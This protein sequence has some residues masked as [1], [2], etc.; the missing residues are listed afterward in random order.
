MTR[1]VALFRGINVGKAKRIAMAELRALL[2][3]LGYGSCRLC[4]TAAM[5]Y[6]VGRRA[7]VKPCVAADRKL[8][9]MLTSLHKL[10]GEERDLNLSEAHFIIGQYWTVRGNTLDTRQ[11]FEVG[12][13]KGV[14]MYI[15]LMA[16]AYELARI[17]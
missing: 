10:K 6:L 3:S 13:S 16:G 15:E 17:K 14:I 9:Q 7:N 12:R 4:S 11:S 5:R 8:S 1:S 2:E